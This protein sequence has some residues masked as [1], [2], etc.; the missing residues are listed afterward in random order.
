MI[1]LWSTAESKK[2]DTY[3]LIDKFDV[4][5]LMPPTED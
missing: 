2:E 5:S 4:H 3:Y 1:K